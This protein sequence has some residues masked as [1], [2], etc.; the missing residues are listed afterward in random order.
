[1]VK[2]V[3]LIYFL[4]NLLYLSA[5]FRRTKCV[6]KNPGARVLVWRG[7]IRQNENALYLSKFSVATPRQKSDK[8]RNEDK[9]RVYQ[10]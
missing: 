7:H 5:W 2:S 8:L 3:N 10:N 4:E 9:G 6:A 1:M